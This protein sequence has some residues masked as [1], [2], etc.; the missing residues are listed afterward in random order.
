MKQFGYDA[1]LNP[2]IKDIQF[3]ETNGVF[4]EALDTFVR[5][6]IFCVCADNLGAHSLAGFHESFNFEHFCRFCCINQDQINTVEARD[7]Q[8]R[9]VEKHNTFLE[10]LEANDELTVN[11]VKKACVLHKHLSH[12]HPVTGFPP[13]ILHDFFEGVVPTELFVS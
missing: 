7:C 2:L 4:L 13:D 5:G 3:M 8:L 6:T 1:F 11:G 12:F 10:E 9:I